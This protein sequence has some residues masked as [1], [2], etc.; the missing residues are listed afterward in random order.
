MIDTNE[1]LNRMWPLQSAIW[2]KCQL[3]DPIWELN[4]DG[5]SPLPP[6]SPTESIPI[7][8][9]FVSPQLQHIARGG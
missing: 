4:H 2:Y 6:T 7:D 3:I 9:I 1:N 5:M 8:G